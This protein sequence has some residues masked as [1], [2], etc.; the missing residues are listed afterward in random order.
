MMEISTT[1]ITP[2]QPFIAS[3]HVK[4][5]TDLVVR[6]VKTKQG[7]RADKLLEEFIE[8]K[9]TKEKSKLKKD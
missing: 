2:E 1:S 7:F 6:D 9:L 5:F 4:K 3:G 8:K